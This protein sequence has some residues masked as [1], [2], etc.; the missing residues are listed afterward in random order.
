M[1]TAMPGPSTSAGQ[2]PR[3]AN[4]NQNER[5]QQRRWIQLI[6]SWQ[7]SSKDAEPFGAVSRDELVEEI[8][9]QAQVLCRIIKDRSW[10]LDA[11]QMA[12][13]AVI[14][15]EADGAASEN[16]AELSRI[17]QLGQQLLQ[18][19]IHSVAAPYL[20][21][22]KAQHADDARSRTV[23]DTM[24]ELEQ[25]S[26]RLSMYERQ[27][28]LTQKL[29][30]PTL[31]LSLVLEEP[32][33]TV[34][35]C[36]ASL[37]QGTDVVG[38]LL[39]SFPWLVAETAPVRL[40][41]LSQLLTTGAGGKGDYASLAASDLLIGWKDGHESGVW[42]TA[43]GLQQLSLEELSALYGNI[44]E[45]LTQV[46][47]VAQADAL[48]AVLTKELQGQ[49][50]QQTLSQLRGKALSSTQPHDKPQEG[51]NTA[52][53]A[54]RQ[55]FDLTSIQSIA[56][57]VSSAHQTE[58]ARRQL[59]KELLSTSD[60]ASAA[61]RVAQ[62]IDT[63]DGASARSFGLTVVSQA[64][65][66]MTPASG[67][68]AHL[69]AAILYARPAVGRF[70]LDLDTSSSLL[71]EANAVLA[72]LNQGHNGRKASSNSSQ[73]GM[74]L[75]S[76][77]QLNPRSAV[78]ACQL[79][80]LLSSGLKEEESRLLNDAQLHLGWLKSIAALV[81][82][83]SDKPSDP[84]LCWLAAYGGAHQSDSS[85][86][87]K[88]EAEQQ[89]RTAFDSLLA[90]FDAAHPP[91]TSL[92]GRPDRPGVTDPALL[93]F[94]A[95]WDA[96]YHRLLEL[97]GSA[98]PSAPFALVQETHALQRLLSQ[99]LRTGDV[100]LFRSL[101]TSSTTST[102]PSPQ[103]EDL[104]LDV[105]TELFDKSNV[106][107]TRSRD[108][109][110]SLDVLSALPASSSRAKSQKD[111]IEAACRLSSFKVK[112]ILHPGAL[113]EPRE[114]RSTP[115]KL[116]LV[117]RLLATQG[118]A[119]RS[120]ELVLDVANRLCG[121]SRT[122]VDKT[123]VEAR[124]LAMLADAAT[125]AEDFEDASNFC[126]RLVDKVAT[127]RNRP[128]AGA[129]VEIAW[130]TCLQLS[131]HPMWEDTPERIAM[132]A[133][134]MTV[135]PPS[136]LGGMLRQWAALDAQLAREVGEGKTFASTRKAAAAEGGVGGGGWL[137]GKGEY[138]AASV[139]AMVG[140]AA[141]MLPLSFSPLS[142]FGNAAA[143][144]G[145]TAQRAGG[146]A[147]EGEVDARTA[148]LFDFDGVS[149]AS[150]GGGGGAGGGGGYVDPTERAV[151]AARA[152]RDFL[153]WK[154]D[155]HGSSGQQQQQGG[156]GLGGFSLSRGVGWLIGD[157]E[158]R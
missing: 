114:I 92:G 136:Q 71:K 140:S 51:S 121:L 133:H 116:E 131:K 66:T 84:D 77:L 65:S 60:T 76:A 13:D 69:T 43:R 19:A 64:A 135:C 157:G 17:E 37:P 82:G 105:S 142:Y 52:R 9:H 103:L 125:A 120:P 87:A 11:F 32:S 86:Q 72:Q 98:S 129:I 158:K 40:S 110:L 107:S 89:Q 62:L 4:T 28:G 44:I 150:S 149:G 115:D 45:S 97:T 63:N 57:K 126:Q 122:L 24:A 96:F 34:L 33:S 91:P 48:I 156:G 147:K 16:T 88:E 117:A 130:K 132:L 106:A 113:M 108:V 95:A 31:P 145:A 23:M 152:A 134:A 127:T 5:Q 22:L 94:R 73:L 38:P 79:L 151:R 141:N 143:G 111:F 128:A 41:I 68:T 112:S 7:S 100:D 93:R 146:G 15:V 67:G 137:G 124:T 154:S 47:S 42:Q 118:D 8:S 138:K 2:K 101:S 35:L 109:R 55:R 36:L 83:Q 78:P 155:Q 39:Q 123:L 6:E 54:P 102:L 49:E 10:L 56:S 104:V 119:H 70:R 99:I 80:A 29:T 144:T 81:E 139:G 75:R 25:L 46:G 148:K 21:S 3:K 27:R 74:A 20:N 58:N 30:L 26:R 50:A 53:S 14:F 12:I 85:A 1:M 18:L 153:G 61:A 59:A 90:S